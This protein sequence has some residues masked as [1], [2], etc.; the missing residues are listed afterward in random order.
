M[1]IQR[2]PY[3]TS[4]LTP[5]GSENGKLNTILGEIAHAF[6][7][8]PFPTRETFVER[9]D[10]GDG[11]FFPDVG[12][13]VKAGLV[14]YVYDGTS[15][16]ILDLPGWK[17]HGVYTPQHFG[18]PGSLKERVGGRV[19]GWL[20]SD[21]YE[22]LAEAQA[23]YPKASAL[24]Q[25]VDSHAMQR[26]VDAIR[27]RTVTSSGLNREI[28]NRANQICF[29]LRDGV[30]VINRSVD[31]TEIRTTH[32]FWYLVGNGAVVI[33]QCIGETG[34]DFLGSRKCSMHGWTMIGD[35]LLGEGCPRSGIMIGRSGPSALA[36]DSHMFGAV[37]IIGHFTLACVHNFA[38]ED[39]RF[40][41]L[42]LKNDL[43]PSV[44]A[45]SFEA[46]SAGTFVLGETVTWAG[47]GSG[48]AVT[49]TT[50][51][52]AVTG[53]YG[54]EVTTAGSLA[55]GVVITGSTSGKT[56]ALLDP[57]YHPAGEATAAE[58]G[59]GFSFCIVQDGENHWGTASQYTSNAAQSVQHSFLRNVGTIDARH[60]GR[61]AAMW[62]CRADSHDYTNS[63]F[64]SDQASG[65]AAV[66]LYNGVASNRLRN[67]I[68]D[69]HIETD[70]ADSDPATGLDYGFLIASA[71]AAR[72]VT[73]HG[74]SL[75]TNLCNPAIG[76]FATTTDVS[77][78]LLVEP[79]IY[80]GT[81]GGDVGQ[82]LF[83]EP[84]KFAVRGGALSSYSENASFFNIADLAANTADVMC[85]D[86]AS[87]NIARSAGGFR[88]T[89]GDFA[90]YM[91]KMTVMAPSAG[92]HTFLQGLDTD[93][94]VNGE[95]EIR[96]TQMRFGVAGNDLIYL[97]SGGLV[98]LA[99][100]TIN[101]GVNVSRYGTAY[102]T[103]VDF[104]SQ[105]RYQGTKV[106]G[107]QQAHIPDSTGSDEQA[108]INDILAA[109]R[110]HGL[111]ASS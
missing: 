49:I 8:G 41:Y 56:A 9:F 59:E 86:E 91:H 58:G 69:V 44:I 74:I 16:E 46:G 54:I 45:G 99:D 93:G 42:A 34:F 73:L 72:N 76:M 94:S 83:H 63:Y 68:F 109:L 25:T 26:M 79:D 81:E 108:R 33:N 87:A 29:D 5:G 88:L 30:Y 31:F 7:F 61:G 23:V 75:R 32:A 105:V 95:I 96:P 18:A 15:T 11:R 97:S 12:T 1:A 47:G 85:V 57:V 35:L 67:L 38:S 107:A 65:G 103:N 92:G 19:Y 70:G 2:W 106:L 82:L 10:N 51:T 110:A 53:N 62:I 77:T 66:V 89:S 4:R 100:N 28:F 17:P 37:D 71:T 60:S 80:V 104:A 36:A 6:R 84:S 90:G 39:A 14:E 43:N 50:T 55:D 52:N 48:K 3:R 20:L 27:G 101:L 111:I 21:R 64:V 102:A 78:V 40:G 98:P 24:S 13:I 22:T